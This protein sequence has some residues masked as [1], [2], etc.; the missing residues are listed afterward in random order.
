MQLGSLFIALGFN[1]SGGEKLEDTR[2][3][4]TRTAVEATAAVA[5]ITAMNYALLRMIQT[6]AQGAVAMKNFVLQTGLSRQ[7]MLGLGHEAAVNDVPLAE[8][9]DT[10]KQIQS[11]AQRIRLGDSGA[12]GVWKLL[13]VDPRGNPMHVLEE[14]RQRLRGIADTGVAREL[15]SRAGISDNVFQMLRNTNTEFAALDQ[16][17]LLAD[18]EQAGLIRLNRAWQDLAWSLRSVKDRFAAELAPALTAVLG[19]IQ[20]GISTLGSFVNWLNSGGKA[21]TFARTA[22]IFMIGGVVALS[23]AFAALSAVILA[24]TAALA[25]LDIVGAPIFLLAA[26]IAAV[27]LVAVAALAG[28]ALQLNDLW[29]FFHGGKSLLGEFVKGIEH[30]CWRAIDL[31]R[32]TVATIKGL[33]LPAPFLAHNAATG[34]AQATAGIAGAGGDHVGM[35]ARFLRMVAVSR[36]HGGLGSAV[37]AQATAGPVVA[38]RTTNVTQ[39]NQTEIQVNGSESPR[40]TARQTK[41]E[42]L[43]ATT[44]AALQVPLVGI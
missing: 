40:E 10:I 27:A 41:N 8:I 33:I 28:I 21:A 31:V 34:A 2:K 1:I 25:I 15:A 7:Q 17:Y 32:R 36:L 11:T 19:I 26:G 14:L 39:H 18:K 6:A 5:G 35:F 29:S 12:L 44:A 16:K 9:T 38:G 30:D 43:S 3:S 42:L 23:A 22:I 4:I 20:K 24:T 13:G 37:A